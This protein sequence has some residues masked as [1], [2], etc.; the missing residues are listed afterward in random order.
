MSGSE[1]ASRDAVIRHVQ[2]AGGQVAALAT[3]IRTRRP[4][5]EV[6]QQLLAARGSLD[7]LL[8]RLVELELET[9]LPAVEARLDIDHLVRT[10]LGRK[11]PLRPRRSRQGSRSRSHPTQIGGA[12]RP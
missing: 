1:D 5:P 11:T 8:V 3:M 7:A 2:R 10:A 9:C 12:T 4:F 6:A